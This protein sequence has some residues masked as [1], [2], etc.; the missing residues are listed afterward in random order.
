MPPVSL[1]FPIRFT[2]LM[3][4]RVLCARLFV[5]HTHAWCLQKLELELQLWTPMWYWE[6]NLGPQ[7]L[8]TP[9]PSSTHI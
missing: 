6:P 4:V 3:C 5:H 9:E 2:Y 8:L 1:F 7:V